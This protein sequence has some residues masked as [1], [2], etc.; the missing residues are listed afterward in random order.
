MSA[1]QALPPSLHDVPTPAAV[2]D[3]TRVRANCERMLDRARKLNVTLRP[4]VK[5][6][7]CVEVGELATRGT[8][9]RI[10]VS[11]LRE[12][13]AFFAAGFNDILYGVPIVPSKLHR[14]AAL[15]N[16]GCDIKV[17]LD[18]FRMAY[19]IG[20]AAR[21]A[22]V[23]IDVLIEI[24]CDGHRGG[25]QPTDR[26]IR[27]IAKILQDQPGTRFAGLMTHAGESYV[28]GDVAWSAEQE[29]KSIVQVADY[30]AASGFQCPILSVGSTPTASAAEHLDGINEMRAGVYTFGDLFQANRGSCELDDIALSVVC[31]IIGHK[32]ERNWI[33]TDAGALAM[34]KDIGTSKQ[35]ALEQG[36]DFGYGQVCDLETCQPITD[37]YVGD[38]NQ[39]H[40]F[41]KSVSGTDVDYSRFQIGTRVRVLPVHAC[42][43][44]ACFGEYY[45]TDGE[46]EVVDRWERVNGW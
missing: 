46:A 34:S 26:A 36:L 7:K 13:E 5:T 32:P 8:R 15:W 16:A 41:I 43:T 45:V 39:E 25:L 6:A 33:L 10:I 42:M 27:Y 18:D 12:A 29:R 28:T 44:A 11:T 21:E 37:L 19:E 4:H 24:D 20:E 9:R 23:T 22:N 40:G 14:V 31:E 30:L 1:E 3:R 17:I 35:A 2:V 38:V